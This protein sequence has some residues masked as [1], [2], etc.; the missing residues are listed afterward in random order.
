MVDI[1]NKNFKIS[2]NKAISIIDNEALLL[3]L[4]TG[5]Y[6]KLNEVALFIVQ[7]LSNFTNLDNIK[8]LVA[9]NFEVEEDECLDDIK[10]FLKKLAERDL[11]EIQIDD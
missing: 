4:G 5:S 9:A 7:H 1:K 6:F 11:L 3:H 8:S 2:D 10:I